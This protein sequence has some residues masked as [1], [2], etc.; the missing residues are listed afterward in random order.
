MYQRNL[1][2]KTK[3][4]LSRSNFH[5][6]NSKKCTLCN[7]RYYVSNKHSLFCDSCKIHN[8]RYRFAEWLDY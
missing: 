8:E 2:A 4:E 3:F 6:L 7:Q 5:T 1:G